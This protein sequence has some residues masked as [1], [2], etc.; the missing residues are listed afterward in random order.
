[1]VPRSWLS[2]FLASRLWGANGSKKSSII[3]MV[4]LNVLKLVWL[5]LVIIRLKA[6]IIMRTLPPLLKRSLFVHFLL[7]LL[8]NDGNST[9]WMFIMPFL[10]GNLDEEIYM[11][12]RPGFT[13]S[14]PTDVCRLK[15]SL[16]GLCQGPR[17]WFAKL[18]TTLL[19]FHSFLF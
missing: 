1:M 6:Y 17:C 10:H 7:L 3:Q 19:W 11:R 5:F 8:Q 12:F 4:L 16:Y 15:K 9:K 14:S 13:F 18:A 2:C